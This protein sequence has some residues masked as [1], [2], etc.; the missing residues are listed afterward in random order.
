MSKKKFTD[1]LADLFTPDPKAVTG[2][3][4]AFLRNPFEPNKKEDQED[5]T[6]ERK[7]T[8][9]RKNF[10]TDLDSL[11]EEALQEVFD[12]HSS[13]NESG[14]GN[15]KV[16]TFHQQTHRRRPYSGL[17]LLIRR[18]VESSPMEVVTDSTNT[19]RL[20]V[21][22]ERKKLEKL[23]KIA[24]MEKAYLKDILSDIVADFIK[25]YEQSKG[26]I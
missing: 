1:G 26:S 15:N 25:N 7:T 20:T 5:E 22:F 24:R 18:T 3:G 23:K 16:K 14:D 6:R 8:S 10:T 4:T 11:L 19:K 2:R 17:D 13:G 21:T 9:H 12:D